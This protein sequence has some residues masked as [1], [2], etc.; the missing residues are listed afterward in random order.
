MTYFAGWLKKSHE[1]QNLEIDAERPVTPPRPGWLQVASSA[2]GASS[3]HHGCTV[4]E[5]G[6]SEPK[7]GAMLMKST[8]QQPWELSSEEPLAWKCPHPPQVNSLWLS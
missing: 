5:R 2:G 8:S 7:V 1:I 6:C 3:L 4:A